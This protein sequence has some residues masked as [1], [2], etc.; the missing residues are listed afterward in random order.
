VHGKP[1]GRGGKRRATKRWTP[2]PPRADSGIW[3]NVPFPEKDAAKQCGAKYDPNTKHWFIPSGVAVEPFVR[4]M[5]RPASEIRRAIGAGSVIGYWRNAV[6]NE[7]LEALAKDAAQ[8]GRDCTLRDEVALPEDGDLEEGQHL[9]LVGYFE[10][11]IRVLLAVPLLLEPHPH[12]QGRFRITVPG[13]TLPR[14][15]SDYLE[16]P[17]AEPGEQDIGLLEVAEAWTAQAAELP[18]PKELS[19]GIARGLD[20]LR[21]VTGTDPLT[22]DLG[23]APG[24]MAGRTPLMA[25]LVRAEEPSGPV[26]AIAELYDAVLRL[27]AKQGRPGLLGRW[28][29]A[30]TTPQPEL[31]L[32]EILNAADN[33]VAHMDSNPKEAGAGRQSF[34]LD[35]SQR[36][37]V[38][39]AARSDIMAVQGPPGT[40]KTSMMKAVV[41]SA[42]TAPLLGDAPNPAP[43]LILATAATNK[44][45]TNVIGG[46]AGVA[47]PCGTADLSSRWLTGIGSFGWFAPSGRIVESFTSELAELSPR[48]RQQADRD[49]QD[50]GQFQLLTRTPGSPTSRPGLPGLHGAASDMQLDQLESMTAAWLGKFREFMGAAVTDLSD[51]TTRLRRGVRK[52]IGRQREARA[53]L[54]SFLPALDI[55]RAAH[56]R[57]ESGDETAG[58]RLPR[59]RER[60][61]TEVQAIAIWQKHGDAL[62]QAID[63]LGSPIGIWAIVKRL[64]N[65]RRDRAQ[66]VAAIRETR[67]VLPQVQV[68]LEDDVAAAGVLLNAVQTE[69]ATCYERLSRG[70]D[71]VAALETAAAR[72]AKWTATRA[73]LEAAAI[74]LLNVAGQ[75]LGGVVPSLATLRQKV[76]SGELP[77]GLSIFH[78]L[79]D[80]I[81]V[82][83]RVEA[84]HLA[85]R[86]WEARFLLHLQQRQQAIRSETIY[87][88]PQDA[89]ARLREEIDPM[90]M[91]APCVVA[92]AHSLPRFACT[93]GRYA[94]GVADLLIIDEAGQASPEIVSASLALARRALVVGDTRQLDPVWSDTP[95]GDRF[96]RTACRLKGDELKLAEGAG[97]VSVGSAML[98]A[99]R[100]SAHRPAM[101]SRHYRC[102]PQII[103][104]C[105]EVVYG[106]RMVPHRDQS[107]TG[108]IQP[109]GHVKV[110]GVAEQPPGGSRQNPIEVDAIVAWLKQNRAAIEGKYGPIGRAVVLI[111]PYRAHA[112]LLEGRVR[113][114]FAGDQAALNGLVV[115]TV[116]RLQGAEA[117]VVVFSACATNPSSTSFLDDK[118]NLLNVAVSR[119]KDSFIVFAHPKMLARNDAKPL[120]RL[121]SWVLLHPMRTT[122]K[123]A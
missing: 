79:E 74:H 118:P 31:R 107:E 38:L 11:R 114:A 52:A 69:L 29:E 24:A 116:H 37:A 115:G 2:P 66:A 54:R 112:K 83:P 76:T 60:E 27:P 45:V 33:H 100:N 62:K 26:R 102:L 63:F 22:G 40:G 117:P 28:T 105:N 96:L 42:M 35:Q 97:S 25:R 94:W 65:G 110:A 43:A 121:A 21:V 53:G 78:A 55:A 59:A 123:D 75:S 7:D 56:G 64:F 19:E 77:D 5:A 111:T 104:W 98:M 41:A 34:P 71:T 122:I 73:A 50:W 90:L 8:V 17:G 36:I 30:A 32:Q 120:G 72:W 70:R 15:N 61:Q 91:L 44:A 48:R 106:G 88:P 84:F 9:L 108:P 1:D 58:A 46:F 67:L 119:A 49:R 103:A 109:V 51:A 12:H 39:T 6:G 13:D 10:D 82:G 57:L 101:L 85:A 20:L 68:G 95:T 47:D 23:R 113:D 14:L 99:E 93:F 81:D 87:Q 4:W 92:T 86:Y 3:L 16:Q 89:D 18:E 80:A